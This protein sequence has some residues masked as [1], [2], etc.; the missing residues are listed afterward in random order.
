MIDDWLT[1]HLAFIKRVERYGDK[2]VFH[3]SVNHVPYQLEIQNIQGKTVINLTSQDIREPLFE[4]IVFEGTDPIEFIRSELNQ[5]VEKA[6]SAIRSLSG[7][8]DE[9]ANLTNKLLFAAGIRIY[10]SKLNKEDIGILELSRFLASFHDIYDWR[11]VLHYRTRIDDTLHEFDYLLVGKTFGGYERVIGV[12]Y[13]DTDFPKAIS[14][15]IDRRQYVDYQY[16]VIKLRAY[17]LIT[18]FWDDLATAKEHGIGILTVDYRGFPEMLLRAKYTKSKKTVYKEVMEWLEKQEQG[19]EEE[20]T[21]DEAQQ[22]IID[23][24]QQ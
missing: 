2:V 8:V 13:K 21:W 17:D 6:R 15:A 5:H 9:L 20:D 3:L 22:R 14:Q 16:I 1:R 4:P 24:I 23:F 12:E 18:N 10:D 19:K 7:Y 11:A